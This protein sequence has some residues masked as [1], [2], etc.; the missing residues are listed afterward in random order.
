MSLTTAQQIFDMAM[1]F[2]DNVTTDGEP[3]SS[4]SLA[5]LEA[6]API[7]ITSTLEELIEDNMN[8]KEVSFDWK[9]VNNQLG[10]GFNVQEFTGEDKT[11]E[12]VGSKVYGIEVDRAITI[13]REEEILGVWTELDEDIV[14]TTDVEFV[15]YAGIITASDP[16]NNV[17]I[18]L[19]GSTYCLYRNVFL[20]E[21]PFPA[22]SIPYYALY[23]PVTL[24]LDFH[25]RVKIVEESIAQPYADAVNFKW[26]GKDKL[27]LSWYFDGNIR[28]HYMFEPPQVTALTDTI[29]IDKKVKIAC[30][31]KLAG[32]ISIHEQRRNAS[33]FLDKYEEQ[34][35][36]ITKKPPK[37]EEE[38]TNVYGGFSGFGGDIYYG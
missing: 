15:R 13:K 22:T 7:L 21:K 10:E 12:A 23:F 17:R 24:P 30:A 8:V 38:I 3:V 37:E 16:A 1:G 14:V 29:D 6:K 9:P 11:F 32:E 5:D 27:L 31:Y 20:S 25:A 33:Y 35:L 18:R 36:V 19:T 2:I 34:R 28:L 4:D 26:E